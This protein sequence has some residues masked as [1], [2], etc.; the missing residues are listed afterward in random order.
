MLACGRVLS[1]LCFLWVLVFVGV[2]FLVCV[3][4]VYAFFVFLCFCLFASL[5]FCPRGFVFL[6]CFCA[7]GFVC[8]CALALLSFFHFWR[9]CVFCLRM[10]VLAS[11][12]LCV[13]CSSVFS[14]FRA[15]V[16]LRAFTPST[17]VSVFCAFVLSF[18]G[19]GV[20]LC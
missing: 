1:F 19:V 15:F 7:F 4:R 8:L 14:C 20:V 17:C 9:I 13:F 6:F 10:C 2:C 16:F 3:S 5:F 12:Y 18:S 11:L